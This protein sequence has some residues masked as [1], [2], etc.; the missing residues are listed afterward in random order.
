VRRGTTGSFVTIST[1]GNE[2]AR[3]FVPST[4]P[5]DPPLAIDDALRE[6]LDLAHVA[7]GRLDSVTSL[8]PDPQLFL[9]AFVRK[10]AVLSSQIEGTQS[11]LE[12]LL[13]FEND[14][15]PE[16]GL[17][18]VREVSNY[19]AALDH[20]LARVR[21]GFPI[22][23]R[24]LREMH[25]RLLAHGRGAMKLP[26]ELRRSQNWIGGNR[27][28]DAVFVPPPPGEVLSC[29]SAL[30]RWIHDDPVRT[31]PLIKAALAHV[32]F[33]TIHPFLDGNGRL[34]R[35]LIA[36]LLATE[37]V[38]HEPLLY[39]SL[40]LKQHRS[41]YYALL[42]QIRDDG[43][44][45]AWLAFFSTGV[46]Q[47]ADG[48]VDTVK[49][50]VALFATHRELLRMQPRTSGSLLTAH[51]AL[52]RRPILSVPRLANMTGLSEPTAQTV[53]RRLTALGLVEELTGKA[54]RRV[55][56]Y[57]PYV[58]LLSQDTEPLPS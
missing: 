50:I 45:E 2:T 27:P 47:T 38:L 11:T 5:P 46:R 8:L 23:T 24:L 20:G 12:D 51:D 6:Q 26:G 43:D 4:L 18:D 32:Q 53:L 28:G 48:A 17:Y 42:S 21:T 31:P 1:V 57:A 37:G 52:Q 41:R 13:L 19:V 7:L 49:R 33:E 14:A 35:L 25:E 16:H 34:G 30:E 58:A 15:V 29:L 55:F 44:W 10:E 54:R 9:Y 40:F 3:A 39:L 36:L 56:S 22:S